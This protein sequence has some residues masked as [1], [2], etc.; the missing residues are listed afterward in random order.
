MKNI[1]LCFVIVNY[2]SSNLISRLLNTLDNKEEQKYHVLIV[3]NSPEEQELLTLKSDTVSIIQAEKNL[4]FG[5]ACNLGLS[6]IYQHD[7]QAIAWL[8]N[9][10]TYFNSDTTDNKISNIDSAIAFFKDHPQISILGTTV[11]NSQGKLTDAGGSFNFDTAALSVVTSLPENIKDDYL[12]TDWVSGCSLLINLANFDQCP[13]FDPRYFLYYEDLDFCLRYGQQGHQIAVTNLIK[14]MHD[15][16]SITNRNLKW[17]Y[18]HVTHSYLIHI[19]K[20]GSLS[21]FIMTNIRMS[22]NTLRLMLFKPQQG[23]GKLIGM[24][25]YWQERFNN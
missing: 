11:Y 14:V 23:M 15:T 6:W 12:K 9:P 24:I 5:Q 13:N 16:S 4:G 8:I 2:N 18:Q 20:Y 17:K 7:N 3:N 25:N 10:D 19:E 21:I 22:L 1:N